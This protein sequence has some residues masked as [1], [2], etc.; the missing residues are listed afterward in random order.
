MPLRYW[1]RSPSWTLLPGFL[2]FQKLHR[3]S[4]MTRHHSKVDAPP[5]SSAGV[6]ARDPYDTERSHRTSTEVAQNRPYA[7]RIPLLR[8]LARESYRF[9][10]RISVLLR[11]PSERD[12]IHAA[13][14]CRACGSDRV[15]GAS[16]LGCTQYT[17]H[18]LRELPRLTRF[19]VALVVRTWSEA[20]R[21]GFC[22]TDTASSW[23]IGTRP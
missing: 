11:R 20:S 10:W 13:P 1:V 6:P 18:L 16:S 23:H 15:C 19:D 4:L 8:E 2:G 5:V 17:E 21:K 22:S 7:W 9:A 3:R 12:S 14:T